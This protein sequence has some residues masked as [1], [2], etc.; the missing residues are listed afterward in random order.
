MIHKKLRGNICLS[1]CQSDKLLLA[2][3][4]LKPSV[5]I[6]LPRH[7]QTEQ[8]RVYPKSLQ[9]LV[10]NRCLIFHEQVE[11]FFIDH[12][13]YEIE[14]FRGFLHNNFGWGGTDNGWYAEGVFD[15]V[16]NPDMPSGAHS[17]TRVEWEGESYNYQFMRNVYTD[18]FR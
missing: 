16:N 13:L 6:L 11:P 10:L 8:I 9:K 15:P 5:L 3:I 12:H 17:A 4:D 7:E 1:P 14:R 18:I 2:P